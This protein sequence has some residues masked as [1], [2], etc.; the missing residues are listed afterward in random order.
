MSLWYKVEVK[1]LVNELLRDIA[2]DVNKNTRVSWAE[3][4]AC[5]AV[6]A[7][8]LIS[9]VD[10]RRYGRLK[11]KLANNYLLGTDQYPD[12]FDKGLRI[13]G[14]YQ[15]SKARM[16]FRGSQYDMGVAFLQLKEVTEEQ[17]EDVADTVKAL[18][19]KVR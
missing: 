19:A 13:L 1:G 12:T 3:E 4:D 15:T 5:K 17:A 8:L 10:T 14:N 2:V 16:P 7:A 6:K 11:D 9:R 18:E